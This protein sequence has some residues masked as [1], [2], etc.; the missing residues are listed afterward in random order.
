MKE[1]LKDKFNQIKTN[2]KDAANKISDTDKTKV[3][4]DV[5]S[6]NYRDAADTLKENFRKEGKV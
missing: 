6:G 3:K 5:K 2:V 1:T 4:S